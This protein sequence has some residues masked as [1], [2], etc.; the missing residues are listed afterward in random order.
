MWPPVNRV[1]QQ[2]II[3]YWGFLIL[4]IIHMILLKG[5]INKLLKFKVVFSSFY[6]WASNEIKA[7]ASN[8][9]LAG[10][11]QNTLPIEL[12]SPS[13]LTPDFGLVFVCK[14]NCYDIG[15]IYLGSKAWLVTTLCAWPTSI[16]STPA[17]SGGLSLAQH[18]LDSTT[19]AGT[20]RNNRINAFG[21]CPL[22]LN[23]SYRRVDVKNQIFWYPLYIYGFIRQFNRHIRIFPVLWSF[24]WDSLF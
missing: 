5:N 11:V 2:N 10:L 4:Y 14:V 12:G 7:Y 19:W 13:K 22:S 17:C 3:F 20:Y 15:L 9:L 24:Y 23:I 16:W 21:I 6:C 1:Q 18:R 8:H